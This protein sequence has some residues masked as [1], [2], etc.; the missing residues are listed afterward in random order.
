MELTLQIDADADLPLHQQIYDQLRDAILT[1]RVRSRQRLPASR[2]L[3]QTLGVSRT[4]VTQSYDQLISEGYLETRPGAGTF[5]C[6]QLPDELLEAYVTPAEHASPPDDGP[7]HDNPNKTLSLSDLP[8]S[9]YGDR[10]THTP[11]R[12]FKSSPEISFTYGVPALDQFPIKRWKQ[13]LNRRATLSTDWMQYSPEPMGYGLLREQIATYIGQVRAVRCQSEQILITNGT[14]QALSLIVRLLINAA[15]PL[16]TCVTAKNTT[17]PTPDCIAI[18]NP[19]YLSATQI[20]ASSGAPLIPIPVDSGGLVIDGPKSLRSCSV[21][22][23]I[24]LVY[25]T[26]SHQFPTGVLMPLS[27]RLALLQWAQENQAIIIEDDYD[28]EFRYSGRPTPALQGLDSYGQVLYVGTF[29]KVMFPGLRLGYIVLPPALIPIFRRAKWLNNRQGTILDQQALTDFIEKGDM[30]Q[31][32]RRMRNLYATRR[33]ALIQGLSEA[34]AHLPDNTNTVK[35]LGDESGLHIMAQLPLEQSDEQV[36]AK[37]K[38]QGVG[39]FSAQ[40]QYWQQ[41]ELTERKRGAFIFGFG[42]LSESDI[43]EAMNRLQP[44]FRD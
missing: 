19:G 22:H 10:L 32:I 28:S 1:G 27:R 29:S 38:S 40:D 34:F 31:H 35:I 43:R 3:A 39:M 13:L 21:T 42:N 18:E 7:N 6:S 5:V 12:I 26:P 36:I 24:K 33:Q 23:A 2:Y 9:A 37:A 41:P 25:V 15:H 30:A 4:T 17:P 14:Q 20:F 44:V 8:L 16:A 11:D